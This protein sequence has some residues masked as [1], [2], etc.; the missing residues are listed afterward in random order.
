MASAD[1][2]AITKWSISDLE[3]P[4]HRESPLQVVL[5]VTRAIC[6]SRTHSRS[7]GGG[8][9]NPRGVANKPQPSVNAAFVMAI[10]S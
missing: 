9:V 2:M 1:V 6:P 4:A 8:L 5:G 10:T 7:T 3:T